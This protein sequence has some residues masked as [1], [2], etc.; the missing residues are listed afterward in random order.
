[1]IT[2]QDILNA[3]K[4]S[5]IYFVYQPI[6]DLK[7]YKTVKFEA[8]A[9][10]A[11][12][13]PVTLFSLIEGY[14]LTEVTPHL[15][16]IAIEAGRKLKKRIN[17]NLNYCDLHYIKQIDEGVSIEIT[18]SCL[19]DNLIPKIKTICQSSNVWID[20]VFADYSAIKWIPQIPFGGVK[21][22]KFL[23]DQLETKYCDHYITFLDGV[24][25]SLKEYPIICEGIET[26]KQAEICRD[27]GFEMAQGYYFSK[28]HPLETWLI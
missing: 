19:S 25:R 28:P 11:R 5:E 23:I 22:D 21:L 1:M 8:L 2:S 14:Q 12:C 3:V 4:N 7:T 24:R 20:D 27:L 16:N 13:D 9:R 15:M 17:I 6:I 10:W 26:Q 18:E